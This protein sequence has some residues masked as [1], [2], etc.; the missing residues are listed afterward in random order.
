MA[1][2]RILVVDDDL[3]VLE[4]LQI[5]LQPAYEVSVAQS[6]TEAIE[7]ASSESFDVILL[8]LMMPIVDGGEVVKRLNALGIP[9]PIILLSAAADLTSRARQLGVFDADPKPVD[10]DRLERKL[11]RAIT[12]GG[13]GSVP[14]AG[15]LPP[16]PG[17]RGGPGFRKHSPAGCFA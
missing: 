14:P 15:G 4:M 6:G 11:Q 5:L 17:G 10:I 3:D 13:S 9:A 8:D 1:K 12:A 16:A 7:L 2:P